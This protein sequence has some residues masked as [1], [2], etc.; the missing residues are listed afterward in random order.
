VQAV[1]IDNNIPAGKKWVLQA[2]Y[3]NAF[4]TLDC[5]HLFK[6]VRAQ[7]P[8]SAAFVEWTYGSHPH[9]YFGEHILVSATCLQQGDP[10]ASLLFAIGIH[11]LVLRLKNEAP[12][13]AI[14]AW[15]LDDGIF[16][17][18]IEDL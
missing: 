12:S 14:L 1:F 2:D 5:M 10:L 7:V 16:V 4:N 11:P 15:Y 18:S 3:S 9:L 8:G 6:E 13:L 17:G